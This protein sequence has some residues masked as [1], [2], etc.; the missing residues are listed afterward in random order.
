MTE[1]AS[2]AEA[3]E[4]TCEAWTPIA[5]ALLGNVDWLPGAYGLP[6]LRGQ[7]RVE[8]EDFLVEEV[9]GFEPDGEGQHRLIHIEKR[10]LNTS[11]VADALAQVAGV[12]RHAVGYGGRKDRRA[13]ARQW[14]SVDL[15]GREEPNWH[16]GLAAL[17]ADRLRILAVVPHRRKLRIGTLA[18]NRFQL[19]IRNVQGDREAAEA[20]WQQIMA[21]GVPNYFGPQRFGEGGSNVSRALAWFA[22]GRPPR[23][24]QRDLLLSAAR[25]ALFNQLLAHRVKDQSWDVARIGDVLQLA[26]RGSWF[27]YGPDESADEIAARIRDGELHPT[28]PLCGA[29]ESAAD[30]AVRAL[31]NGLVATYPELAAGLARVGLRHDRRALRVFP[32][33][34]RFCWQ[35]SGLMLS[36][37]L[38]PGAFATTVVKEL[39]HPDGPDDASLSNHGVA[40]D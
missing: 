21:C 29:G 27:V 3:T 34:D 17:L 15:A 31:E 25:S 14:F 12:A 32:R 20:R 28:G 7:L 22:G 35:D 39:L 37:T 18:G 40:L 16:A 24:S 5:S 33:E 13:V 23:R 19:H 26:G 4:I 36:F 9:L 2:C 6:P 10:L 1:P 11:E 8:P 38:P 30:G